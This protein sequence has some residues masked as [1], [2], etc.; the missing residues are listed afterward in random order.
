MIKGLLFIDVDGTLT[1]G[2]IYMGINGEIMKAFSVKD[3]CGIQ[4]IVDGSIALPI[5]ISGRES[6]IVENR[7]KE[8]EVCNCI[9]GAKDKA[10]VIK[11]YE[12]LFPGCPLAYIGD[13]LNDIDA[14]EYVKS[15]NGVTAC[16]SDACKNVQDI[17]DYVCKNIG[18]N[19]AVREFID[20]L[21]N[22]MSL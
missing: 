22:T 19:G 12:K 14:M 10:S 8:L 21:Y 9:Q 16:P 11:E 2:K 7:C 3:G 5:V 6:K 20:Y 17:V 1:D 18:G 15:R 4:R 13:D